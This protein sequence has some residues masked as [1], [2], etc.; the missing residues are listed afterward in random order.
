MFDKIN[1]KYDALDIKMYSS[2]IKLMLKRI[3]PMSE[4]IRQFF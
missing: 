4:Q 2:R 3:V 1:N